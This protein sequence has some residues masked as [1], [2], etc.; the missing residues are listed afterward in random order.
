VDLVYK[1]FTA[2]EKNHGLTSMLLKNTSKRRFAN[3]TAIESPTKAAVDE[4]LAGE[5]LCPCALV[6]RSLDDSL[7]CAL[8]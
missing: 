8:S 4:W 1:M 5:C 7:I 6:A 2:S 3:V